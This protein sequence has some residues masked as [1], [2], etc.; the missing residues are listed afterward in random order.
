[1]LLTCRELRVLMLALFFR[2]YPLAQ[3]G[4]LLTY[5]QL[6]GAKNETSAWLPCDER[7]VPIAQLD[8]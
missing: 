8:R 1:M 3:P 5:R 4:L 7:C 6:P 2:L